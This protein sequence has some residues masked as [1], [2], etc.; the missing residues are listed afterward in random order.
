MIFGK[1][2]NYIPAEAANDFLL[3]MKNPDFT[4]LENSGHSGFLEEPALVAE[5][6]TEFI[7]KCDL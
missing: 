4:F 5:K 6:C 1:H 7:K 2:D 3:T